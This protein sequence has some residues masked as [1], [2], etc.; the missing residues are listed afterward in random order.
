MEDMYNMWE[1]YYTG[2]YNEHVAIERMRKEA[3]LR[4][5]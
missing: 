2:K 1:V 3:E 4:R 5:R